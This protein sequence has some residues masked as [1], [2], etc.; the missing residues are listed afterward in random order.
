MVSKRIYLAI[1]L[2]FLLLIQFDDRIYFVETEWFQIYWSISILIALIYIASIFACKPLIE[3]PFTNVDDY[4]KIWNFILMV[5]S[6]FGFYRSGNEFFQKLL[7]KGFIA[8]FCDGDYINNRSIYYWYFL[9]VIS[10]IFEM[11]DTVFLLLRKKPIRFIHW[12]HHAIT[13]IYTFYIAAHLPAIGR[14]MCTMNF[15]VHS[16]MY[17][18]YF[19]TSHRIFP[20]KFVS[21][22]IT[23]LQTLQMFIGIF[24]ISNAYYYKY[25]HYDCNN[26][27]YTV[28]AGLIMYLIYVCLFTKLFFVELKRVKTKTK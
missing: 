26:G 13:M 4:L 3:K 25:Y 21:V 11:G 14:W 19:V 7:T 28:E 22:F 5:F 9:F 23:T 27:G 8:S 10:K 24:V 20:P 17:S 15:F 2:I 18:Y 12:F 6:I 1:V 16:F